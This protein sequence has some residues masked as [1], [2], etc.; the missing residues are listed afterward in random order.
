MPGS[1]TFVNQ[2]IHV[3]FSYLVIMFDPTPQHPL[4]KVR[5]G[6]P[7]VSTLEHPLRDAPGVTPPMPSTR[8]QH[9][10]W[11]SARGDFC[12]TVFRITLKRKHVV[13][14]D[15]TAEHLPGGSMLRN[16]Y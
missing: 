8:P 12:P 5:V 10:F 1:G 11:V 6:G 3:M 4:K 15:P 16:K 2:F 7:F 14:R 9:S 13:L